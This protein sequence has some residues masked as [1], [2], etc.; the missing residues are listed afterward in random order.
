MHP[1]G[2]DDYYRYM[3]DGKV[4]A[5]GINPY[6]YAPADSALNS[7]HTDSLPGLINF[8]DM[9]SIYPPLTQILF[10]FSY[11][12][13]GESFTGIKI[14]L[15]LSDLLTLWGIF[16]LLKKLKLPYKN[17]LIYALCSL[18][19]F[20]FFIDAHLDGFG[21]PLIIF[22]I[23]F[24][25][26][27]RKLLSLIFLSASIC[28]KP[29]GLILIPIFFFNEKGFRDKLKII[30]VPVLLCILMYL[31]YLFTG[32]PFQALINFT[33]NWTFNGIIF[34]VLDLVLKDNQHTRLICG[35]IFLF[36]YFP[37]VLSRQDLITK[38]YLSIFLLFIFS[39]V[40]HPWY[41]TWLAVLLPFI[42][43]WSGIAYVS[44][45]SLTSFTILNY[46]LNGTW[47]EYTP[48]LMIEYIPVLAFFSFEL[49][50]IWKERF[51]GGMI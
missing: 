29:L 8:P 27:N 37:V 7:L 50:R 48:V 28:I 12:T 40:V 32:S 34:N 2:S 41:L 1:I 49:Y 6:K 14:F 11:L 46:H 10:Y 15:L 16:L 47:K 44:L 19:I 25:L 22:T 35:I 30:I 23:Y 13:G 4:Q 38:I 17:V 51:K 18:P 20:Q 3:W 42:P 43:R 24:Y 31:P 9:R 36:F 39:P 26:N 45:I 33:E 5:H 21:L